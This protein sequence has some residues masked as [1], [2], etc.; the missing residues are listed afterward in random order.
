MASKQLEQE[1]KEQKSLQY[2][3]T[4]HVLLPISTIT[5]KSKWVIPFA[6]WVFK[7]ILKA[8][9]WCFNLIKL[10]FFASHT[11]W[12]FPLYN[13]TNVDLAHVTCHNA[14]IMLLFCRQIKIV[15]SKW[16]MTGYDK[17]K[18]GNCPNSTYTFGNFFFSWF[19]WGFFKGCWAVEKIYSRAVVL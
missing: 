7:S 17:S 15:S 6:C 9:N 14:Y 11:K 5:A 12:S 16:E 4:K 1:P 18:V 3:I 13:D 10:S 19:F 2:L 8:S